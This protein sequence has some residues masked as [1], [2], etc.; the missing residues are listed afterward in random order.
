M[1]YLD[2]MEV[3]M[4]KKVTIQIDGQC[5]DLIAESL[6][7][8]EYYGEILYGLKCNG[9]IIPL[10][11]DDKNV[12]CI[13]TFS[14][15]LSFLKFNLQLQRKLLASKKNNDFN[16][17]YLISLNE[18]PDVIDKSI[19]FVENHS[20][21]I[22]S[23]YP[24]NDICSNVR[25]GGITPLNIGRMKAVNLMKKLENN[26]SAVT[27]KLVNEVLPKKNDFLYVPVSILE[28]DNH[29]ERQAFKMLAAE[30]KLDGTF[31]FFYIRDDKLTKKFK[32]ELKKGKANSETVISV[33]ET[34]KR[35]NSDGWEFY[36]D[37]LEQ[38]IDYHIYF[39]PSFDLEMVEDIN[40][41][42]QISVITLE[43]SFKNPTREDGKTNLRLALFEKNILVTEKRTFAPELDGYNITK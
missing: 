20:K 39:V 2:S 12:F 29:D 13:A 34:R 4:E 22:D 43:P 6:V 16:S 36:G 9:K 14:N 18:L 27:T 5:F 33:V 32:E 23:L 30:R 26:H 19:E 25:S 21:S 42:K 35:R 40:N 31:E 8:I 17:E 28:Q 38:P 11:K 15:P 1:V 3:P 7:K 37:V 24:N 41:S 10:I